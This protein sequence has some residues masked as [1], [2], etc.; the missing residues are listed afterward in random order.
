MKT[1]M[2]QNT[3]LAAILTF[4]SA[5]AFATS[6]HPK[7]WGPKVSCELMY[8][9]TDNGGVSVVFKRGE[10]VPVSLSKVGNYE[11]NGFKLSAALSQI[12]AT[13]GGP[14]SNTYTLITLIKKDNSKAKSLYTVHLPASRGERSSTSLEVGNETAFVNCDIQ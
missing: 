8:S 4:A 11:S 10:P 14:C 1:N 5:S 6:L 7:T 9:Q 12:C 13:D 3:V 2:I